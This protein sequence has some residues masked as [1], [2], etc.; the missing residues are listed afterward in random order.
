MFVFA[1]LAIL[2]A[3]L[4][5]AALVVVAGATARPA[6]ASAASASAP[7]SASAAPGS[8]PD[9][10]AIDRFVRDQLAAQVIPG[11]ALVVTHGRDVV[12]VRGFG[13]TSAGTAV[14]PSTQFRLGSVS[15]SFTATAVL[16]LVDAGRVRLDAPVRT[17]L[18][19]SPSTISAAPTSPSGS[20]STTPAG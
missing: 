12:H 9:F 1:A 5:L 13:H 2:A 19:T 18:R 6:S 20:C 17:Y 10:A 3:L 15:K 8:S 4:T 14:T 7:A 16:Q 11:A